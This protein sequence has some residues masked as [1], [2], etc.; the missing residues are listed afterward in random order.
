MLAQA[1][2]VTVK[3]IIYQGCIRLAIKKKKKNINFLRMKMY[4][5]GFH[6][7]SVY[8]INIKNTVS[9]EL[10]LAKVAF[11]RMVIIFVP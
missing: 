4:Q 2:D 7:D 10:P 8:N 11:N 1:I 9:G 3:E 6:R 5:N